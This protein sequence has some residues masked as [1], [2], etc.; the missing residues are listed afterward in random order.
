METCSRKEPHHQIQFSIIHR[1]GGGLTSL[2]EIESVYSKFFS[3]SRIVSWIIHIITIWCLYVCYCYT[4]NILHCTKIFVSII[5]LKC[6]IFENKSISNQI[7]NF[8]M[9]IFVGV[10]ICTH[11]KWSN[12]SKEI[13]LKILNA[14][15]RGDSFIYLQIIWI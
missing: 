5:Q 8:I 11:S 6:F 4:P 1:D 10:Y 7:C 2:L 13:T 3:Q 15:Y 14:N 12:F 9:C